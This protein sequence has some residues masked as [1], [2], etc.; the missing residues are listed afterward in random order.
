MRLLHNTEDVMDQH[1][2]PAL[3]TFQLGDQMVQALRHVRRD[4]AQADRAGRVA[5]RVHVVLSGHLP[6][7]MGQRAAGARWMRW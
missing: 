6:Q 3:A 1:R 5:G 7:R 4:R 2:R